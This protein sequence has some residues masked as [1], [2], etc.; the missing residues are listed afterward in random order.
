MANEQLSF[1]PEPQQGWSQK[2]EAWGWRKVGRGMYRLS[3]KCPRCKH[4]MSADREVVTLLSFLQDHNSETSVQHLLASELPTRVWVRCNCRVAHLGGSE[5][6][7][8]GQEAIIAFADN[9]RDF[10]R[11]E[12]QADV[13]YLLEE[14]RD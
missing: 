9:I 7:G 2:V 8:C 13:R 4:Q 1:D 6:E 5:S 3:G 10:D 14:D 11:A 12:F